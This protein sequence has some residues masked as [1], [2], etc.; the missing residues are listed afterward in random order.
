MPV[1]IPVDF[2]VSIGADVIYGKACHIEAFFLT[3][4]YDQGISGT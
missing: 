1:G 2:T 3:S 4:F